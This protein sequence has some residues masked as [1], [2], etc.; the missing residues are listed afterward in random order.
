MWL[1]C[2]LVAHSAALIMMRVQLV[3]SPHSRSFSCRSVS[4]FGFISR[5]SNRPNVRIFRHPCFV[6]ISVF[7]T[8]LVSKNNLTFFSKKRNTD[9]HAH[10]IPS[11]VMNFVIQWKRRQTTGEKLL[12][13]T[14]PCQRQYWIERMQTGPLGALQGP[15]QQK[16]QAPSVNHP[17]IRVWFQQPIQ[18]L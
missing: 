18:F 10:D 6:I 16:W 3:V 17:V 12:I 15:R 1:V 13:S 9:I 7:V 5:H 4:V 2:P 11:L 8:Q 14:C